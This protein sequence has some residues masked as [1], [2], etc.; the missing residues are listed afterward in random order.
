MTC[1]HIG[2]FA[3][4]GS[5]SP[6]RGCGCLQGESRGAG[7]RPLIF[8][9]VNFIFTLYAM[10][11]K[12]F[13]KL[14]FD[15]I[16]AEIRGV[17]GSVGVYACVCLCDPRGLHDKLVVFLSNIGAFRNRGRYSF[18]FCKGPILIPRPF[19]SQKY[20]PDCRKS[21]LIFFKFSGGGP[22]TLP[23]ALS[24]SAIGSGLRPLTGPL[25]PKFLDLHLV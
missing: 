24:P 20:M 7:A 19:W 22:Q 21:H 2:C 17:F 13:L 25:F 16:V 3:A 5:L 4:S 9:K 11:E 6:F 23:P 15:F 8:G 1:I 14:N 10:S 12:I 18:L